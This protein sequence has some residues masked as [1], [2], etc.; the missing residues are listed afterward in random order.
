M[1]EVYGLLQLLRIELPP[2]GAANTPSIRQCSY[3]ACSVPGHPLE[4][5]AQADIRLHSKGLERYALIKVP[6]N[7]SF[8]TD[9]CQSGQWVAMHGVSGLGKGGDTPTLATSHPNVG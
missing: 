5:A 9:G 1:P 4:G 3:T 8:P 2:L 7:Q 6:T